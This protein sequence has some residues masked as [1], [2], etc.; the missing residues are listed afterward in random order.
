MYCIFKSYRKNERI[1][2]ASGDSETMFL[3]IGFT[4]PILLNNVCK[5]SSYSEATVV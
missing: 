2:S 4:L 1:Y 3:S 5:K